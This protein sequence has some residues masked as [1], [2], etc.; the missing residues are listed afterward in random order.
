MEECTF[1]PVMA[2][3]GKNFSHQDRNGSSFFERNQVW[4]DQVEHRIHNERN[5]EEKELKKICKFT[6]DIKLSEQN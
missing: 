5:K 2:T 1:Q 4:R 6:P 3:A